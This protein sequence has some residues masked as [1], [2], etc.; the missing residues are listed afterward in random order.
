MEPTNNE[1]RPDSSRRPFSVFF[2][3][4]TAVVLA[5]VFL[6]GVAGVFLVVAWKREESAHRATSNRL[7]EIGLATHNMNDEKHHVPANLPGPDGKPG[8]SWRVALLPFIEQ[9]S[10]YKKFHLNEAWDSPHN[11]TLLKH[12]PETYSLPGREKQA[13]E[14]LTY[15]QGFAGP[16][17]VFDP[18]RPLHTCLQH[19]P[20]GVGETILVVEAADPVPWTKPVDLT[21]DP[22]GPLPRLGGR[23]HGGFYL[24]TCDGAVRFVTPKTSEKTLRAAIT[25]NGNDRLGKDW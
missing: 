14:G 24:L 1:G 18:R 23:F 25:Y 5:G 20:D 4:V 2:W 17:A 7:K 9:E 6:V 3:L 8:L 11:L 12:M 22:D 21:D 13:A 10:L 19:F 16:G 15:Y